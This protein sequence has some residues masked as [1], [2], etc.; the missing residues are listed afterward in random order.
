MTPRTEYSPVA[1]GVAVLLG[2]AAIAAGTLALRDLWRPTPATHVISTAPGR[3]AVGDCISGAWWDEEEPEPWEDMEKA[4]LF[5][6]I[7]E[8]GRRAYRARM[9]VPGHGWADIDSKLQ[10]DQRW[11]VMPC[12][13]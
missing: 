12:P 9:W 7:E 2:I 13:A 8:V 4:R 10:M 6:R 5:Y 3:F 11:R 1:L